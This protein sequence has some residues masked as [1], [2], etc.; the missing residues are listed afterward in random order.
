MIWGAVVYSLFC[1]MSLMAVNSELHVS[2]IIS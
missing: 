1:K 2:A